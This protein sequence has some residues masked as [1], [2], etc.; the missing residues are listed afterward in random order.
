VN[1][2]GSET[3]VDAGHD[4]QF[5]CETYGTPR[6]FILWYKDQNILDHAQSRF[7]LPSSIIPFLC[8]SIYPVLSAY[9][10]MLIVVD[11]VHVQLQ[12]AI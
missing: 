12:K 8:L 5:T 6:P 10:I 11:L 2:G 7:F 4:V 3:V 9:S 1:A